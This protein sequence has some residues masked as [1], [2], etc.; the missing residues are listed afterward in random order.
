MN[1]LVGEEGNGKLA[2]C[3]VGYLRNSLDVCTEDAL[4]ALSLLEQLGHGTG[5][6]GDVSLHLSLLVLLP[7]HSTAHHHTND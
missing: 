4:D 6:L 7:Q 3:A 5:I 1:L 2:W